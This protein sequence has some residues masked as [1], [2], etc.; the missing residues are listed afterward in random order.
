[1]VQ[2]TDAFTKVVTDKTA[3]PA[4]VVPG[5]RRAAEIEHDAAQVGI[6][7]DASDGLQSTT[8]AGLM[9]TLV[10]EGTPLANQLATDK[11]TSPEMKMA[12]AQ[13]GGIDAGRTAGLLLSLVGMRAGKKD[14]NKDTEYEKLTTGVPYEFHDEIMENDNLAAAQRAR[15]RV[16]ADLD[17]GRRMTAQDSGGLVSMAASMFDVDLPL[18]VMSGG[19]YGSAKAARL[20]LRTE[21]MLGRKAGMRVSSAL[22]ATNAGAQGGFVVGAVDAVN[23]ESTS[24]QDMAAMTFQSALLGTGLGTAMTGEARAA[25][26]A[27]Q[28]D[29]NTRVAKD[30][31][32]L[33]TD[34]NVE[35]TGG[36]RGNV[37]SFMQ[38][39]PGE[40]STVGAM[41]VAGT[42]GVGSLSAT[43]TDPAG[44]IAP[45]QAQWI[46]G[47]GEWRHDTGWQDRKDEVSGEFWTKAALHP[48]ANVT[49]SFFKGLYTSKSAVANWLAGRVF[50]SPSGLGRGAPATVATHSEVYHKKIMQPIAREGQAAATAWARDNNATAM[51]S[52]YGIS[53][54]GLATFNREVMLELNS[55]ALGRPPQGGA[56]PHIIRAADAYDT[57][58][59]EAHAVGKGRDGEMSVDGFEDIP[60]KNGYTPYVWSGASIMDAL[61]T[62]KAT[63]ADIIDALANG[64]A[65]SGVG[66][67]KDALAIAK[68]VVN[69]AITKEADIDGSV[70][71]LLSGDGQVFLRQSLELAGTPVHEIDAILDR[72]VGA[73]HNRAKEGFAKT[74]NE[75]DLSTAIRT[76]DGSSMKI[77]DLLDTNLHGVWQRY[78]RRMAGSGALARAG[79]INR[80]ERSEMIEALRA[81]QR[82][83]GEVPM[84]ADLIEAMLS[85]F[86]GGALKGYAFGQTNEGIGV[87]TSMA[88]RVTNLALL[89][90]LGLTQ[91][92]ETGPVA[93]QQGLQNWAR[94]GP[95]ALFD[96]QLKAGN[97]AML[98][99][100]AFFTGRI[101]EDHIYMAPYMD[102]DD[103]SR[104]DTNEYLR[105]A[106]T[107]L[108]NA[109]WAQGYTSA[110]NHVKGWQQQT[111]ALGIADKVFRTLRDAH[112]SGTALPDAVLRR[113][114]DDF[115]LDQVH[116][117]QLENL[118]QQGVVVFKTSGNHTFVDRLNM[119]DWDADLAHAFGSSITRGVNQSVQKSMA[120]EQDAWMHTVAGSVMTHL[121][122][123]PLT[124]IQ[125]QVIRNG[126]HMDAESMSVLMYGMATAYVAVRV[127][128]AVEGKE[129]S[130]AE[131]AK[132]AFSY[133]NM[134]G[135]IPM[136]FDPLMTVIG[137]ED[138]R[139]NAYGPYSDL[140]PPVISELNNLR[141]A[142][143]AIIDT[144][145]GTADW[146][147]E[148][149][150]KALPFAN[151]YGM[152]RMFDRE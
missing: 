131:Y 141:R 79:I 132:L 47:A 149:A 73:K 15:A 81:E 58:G 41:Q 50:E 55:R 10:Q 62:G 1:M 16:M 40:G 135:F 57:A 54:A 6:G 39:V 67:V 124:A 17:R 114:Q 102:L 11:G 77:V 38:V 151:S 152:S 27:A 20:G 82:A 70:W 125:K 150:L 86:N 28:D 113:L 146:Y 136:A 52:G 31:P 75:I 5:S 142:P 137:M 12:T 117:D 88:K 65:A 13:A 143:G 34:L 106:Q 93:A 110:F 145:N 91:L 92:A 44:T 87:L 133:S 35:R 46:D 144:L 112:T 69:R 49:T 22:M 90:K 89:G 122:T 66:A 83:L 3:A 97:K 8:A 138:M 14:Y 24:W 129:R 140:T 100:M 21:A 68:A 45:R 74:R 130:E 59:K 26:R 18:T 107:F 33:R 139:F 118:I 61:K 2:T 134:T 127:K 111:A 76:T 32:T 78:S 94:R 120:G 60:T 48:A 147:D 56:N 36:A 80:A 128:D 96:A 115:G 101:G 71:S 98:D 43:L 64:Y 63:Q 85:E 23:R 121:K 84:E 72:L 119:Q 9:D 7:Q 30:D 105:T 19:A 108:S 29:F 116:L 104:A 99:D 37:K 95:M 51:G 103:V 4:Y 148:R 42:P 53:Q 126:R 123:F 25:W 109:Q